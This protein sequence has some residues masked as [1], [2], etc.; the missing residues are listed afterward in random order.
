MLDWIFTYGIIFF[1]FL[2]A[3]FYYVLSIFLKI[4]KRWLSTVLFFSFVFIIPFFSIIIGSQ[5]GYGY[6]QHN[7]ISSLRTYKN[8]LI[9]RDYFVGRYGRGDFSRI[10]WIDLAEGKVVFKEK[11]K[12]S[13][14]LSYS[15]QFIYFNTANGI[16]ILDVN[17]GKTQERFSENDLES[18][19]PKEYQKLDSYEFN[20]KDL[21]VN[22]IDK[23]GQSFEYSLSDFYP[24]TNA[25]IAFEADFV[26]HK[27][28]QYESNRDK[29]RN[30][31][32]KGKKRRV[33][34]DDKGK[35]IEPEQVFIAGKFLGTFT[36]GIEDKEKIS[37]IQSFET[38][39]K[40]HYVISVLDEKGKLLWKF[41]EKEAGIWWGNKVKFVFFYQDNLIFLIK[42]RLFS[43][44]A[45]TGK[46]NWKKRISD[47]NILRTYV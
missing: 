33:L 11:F 22:L 17:T 29:S 42:D 44:Q 16:Y 23:K 38:L 43:F 14:F 45:Q 15:D 24:E 13:S 4:D 12:K 5:A 39:D 31:Q 41:Q 40:D 20:P 7:H 30:Y 19:L 28:I 2:G 27:N 6:L 21:T 46:L 3:G 18:F 10:Y 8:Y 9:I 25:T 34:V 36:M 35:T 47:Y 37:V 1:F 26:Q 32:L